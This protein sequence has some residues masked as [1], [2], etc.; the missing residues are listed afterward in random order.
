MTLKETLFSKY[1]NDARI[2]NAYKD[3]YEPIS[4]SNTLY[5]TTELAISC[6][7]DIKVDNES[8]LL[9]LLY[10]PYKHKLVSDESIVASYGEEI[11]TKLNTLSKLYK[12]DFTNIKD[13]TQNLKKMLISIAKD[14]T[15]IIIIICFIHAEL[16]IMKSN[17][18]DE[19]R[20]KAEIVLNIYAPLASRLGLAIIKGSMEDLCFK[21]MHPEKYVELSNIVDQRFS[22]VVGQL[23]NIKKR[24]ANVTDRLK[25]NYEIHGRKKH[26][27]SIHKKLN[28]KKA[29]LDDIYDIVALRIIVDS[30]PEC[31][32]VLGEVHNTF[33]PMTER[34][35]D[36][37]SL[38][39]QNGYQSLHTTVLFNDR[40][41]E[42]Q[43]RT[44]EMHRIAEY[45]IAAHWMYKE[46]R[47]KKTDLDERLA[48]VREI[49]DDQKEISNEE[50]IATLKIDVF[51]DEI[52]VQ[53]PKGD[54]F[55]FPEGATTIDF[56][57]YIHSNVG[58]KCVG[59]KVNGKM[60]PIKTTLKSGDTVEIITSPTAKGPSRDWL[61]IVR[62]DVAREKIN[63]FFKKELKEDNIKKGKV[64][65][66]QYAKTQ[67]YNLSKLLDNPDIEKLFDKY[68]FTNHDDMYASVGFGSITATKIVSR[69]K[70]L[71]TKY[72]Q[73]HEQLDTL[74]VTKKQHSKKSRPTDMI[75]VNNEKGVLTKLAGCCTPI[76][77]DEIVGFVSHGQGITV[78][79]RD[80]P[81]LSYVELERLIKTEWNVEENKET[82]ANIR[83]ICSKSPSVFTDISTQMLKNDILIS[84]F[85]IIKTEDNKQIVHISI[86]I[87]NHQQLKEV[88]NKIKNIP[89]VFDIH[90]I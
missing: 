17:Y 37:I 38:P 40:P 87:K 11:H 10:L 86:Q 85:N 44:Q 72:V 62:T 90:R 47:D 78:H 43:I 75:L 42:V 2:M 32:A 1:S 56:A 26:V 5:K 54:I 61:K 21:I 65:L 15:S 30:I 20:K 83:I 55:Q 57:Y 46:K 13:E 60:V 22:S 51:S 73:K 58:N 63:A 50:L 52:F 89:D 66:E 35:K 8:I 23:E 9:A 79:R 49:L 18:N 24:L 64:I 6:L 76:P 41:I 33:V 88:L 3:L 53:T 77:G 80:C 48:W 34:F 12:T 29:T 16:K 45:G 31:Y 82:S 69:L 4:A 39:K 14:L 68:S 27:Y 81:N 70:Q 59:A 67:G 74:K 7:A 19:D 25:I 28:D 84:S 71:Y 36:Y